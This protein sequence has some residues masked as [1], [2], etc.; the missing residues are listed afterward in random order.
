MISSGY[1]EKYENIW[2]WSFLILGIPN[3][4]IAKEVVIKKTTAPIT[5]KK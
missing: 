2:N 5:G 3:F 4:I 1:H